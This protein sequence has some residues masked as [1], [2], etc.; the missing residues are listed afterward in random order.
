MVV[1]VW[2]FTKYSLNDFQDTKEVLRFVL[3]MY[4]LKTISDRVIN[5]VTK[6]SSEEPKSS[7]EMVNNR[8]TGTSSMDW[9]DTTKEVD[10]LPLL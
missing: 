3:Y 1:D 7:T 8:H 2:W 5:I 4:H 9:N 10:S 6:V